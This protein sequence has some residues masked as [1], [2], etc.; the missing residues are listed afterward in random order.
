TK[1]WKRPL[2]RLGLLSLLAIGLSAQIWL[3]SELATR[4]V[5]RLS[6]A[7][8]EAISVPP[9]VIALVVGLA[10]VSALA[11][12]WPTLAQ[13][14]QTEPPATSGNRGQWFYKSWLGS[15]ALGVC[16]TAAVAGQWISDLN[17]LFASSSW[18]TAPRPLD[19]ENI[20]FIIT[21]HPST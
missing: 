19:L 20:T 21:K 18:R 3:S 4:S 13:A 8:A 7:M 17:L 2:Q 1:L 14:G 6:P 15:L 16:A 9:L 11:V 5:W 10:L 12:L